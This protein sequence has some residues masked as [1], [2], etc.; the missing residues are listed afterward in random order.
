MAIPTPEPGLV[1]SYAYLWHREHRVGREEGHKDRPSVIVFS[2]KKKT[3][4]GEDKVF[5]F[6]K[7]KEAKRTLFN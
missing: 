1:I 6:L 2:P 3:S 7:E 5:F 4:E